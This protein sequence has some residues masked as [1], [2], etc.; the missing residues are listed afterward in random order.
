MATRA[1]CSFTR[2]SPALKHFLPSILQKTK[3]PVLTKCL[4]QSWQN[5][6][7]N[8]SIYHIGNPFVKIKLL[9]TCS[10]SRCHL[11]W[12][13]RPPWSRT[14]P[15]VGR[16]WKS[17]VPQLRSWTSHKLLTWR[18]M[19]D[20]RFSLLSK[21]VRKVA[22]NQN[23]WGPDRQMIMAGGQINDP[24]TIEKQGYFWNLCPCLPVYERSDLIGLFPGSK[25]ATRSWGCGWP[26]VLLAPEPEWPVE[27]VV[28]WNLDGVALRVKVVELHVAALQS[29]TC[30]M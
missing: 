12:V 27:G 25:G 8:H 4:H 14:A 18:E 19:F 20:V 17:S 5:Y 2:T 26:R 9:F 7:S 6:F 10:P 24:V 30:K 3:K 15:E 11:P 21:L 29:L 13:V 23:C 22:S 1:G 16:D 28:L